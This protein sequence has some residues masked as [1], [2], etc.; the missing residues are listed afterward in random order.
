MRY[1]T[2]FTPTCKCSAGR[3]TLRLATQP[4]KEAA[5][6]EQQEKLVAMRTDLFSLQNRLKLEMTLLLRDRFYS[7]STSCASSRGPPVPSRWRSPSV[8]RVGQQTTTQERG[9]SSLSQ[10]GD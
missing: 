1:F 2:D 9:V 6:R 4:G 10:W 8:S 5:T 7:T 3:E